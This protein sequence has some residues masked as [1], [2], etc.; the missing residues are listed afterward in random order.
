M[1][2]SVTPIAY[3]RYSPT[4]KG[5]EVRKTP[6]KGFRPLVLGDTIVRPAPTPAELARLAAAAG[7]QPPPDRE[8]LVREF[9]A[10]RPLGASRDELRTVT[11]LKQIHRVLSPMR[12]RG[13]VKALPHRGKNV[14]W[15]ASQFEPQMQEF[16]A[17]KKEAQAERD[18][19][20]ARARARL[21]N[22]WFGG[23]NE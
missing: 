3:A 1:G 22:A 5:W 20:Q 7:W 21:H 17:Q 10:T 9:L 16:M 4:L 11:G 2:D 19:E 8:A 23:R 14:R 6:F 13:E 15:Y 18:R 12:A